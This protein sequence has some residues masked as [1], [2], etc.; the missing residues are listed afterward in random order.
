L[1]ITVPSS[2]VEETTPPVA[3]RVR[4][5]IAWSAVPTGPRI[6][7]LTIARCRN[8]HPP[9]DTPAAAVVLALKI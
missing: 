4:S 5:I 8:A 3:S 9:G 6:P 7:T 1:R 2:C